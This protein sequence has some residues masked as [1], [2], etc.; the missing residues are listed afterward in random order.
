M[1][2]TDC[3]H[4]LFSLETT[5]V[6]GL[7]CKIGIVRCSQCGTAI[8]AFI[9]QVLDALNAIGGKLDALQES[10]KRLTR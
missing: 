7:N 4:K 3:K 2:Q 5:T 1:I 9:P 10:I 6:N 8:G